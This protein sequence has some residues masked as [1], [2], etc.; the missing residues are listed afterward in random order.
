MFRRW[1]CACVA[2]LSLATQAHAVTG[3]DYSDLWWNPA[4]NGWGVGLQRQ[5]EVMFAALFLYGDDGASSWY[6]ASDMRALDE[7]AR[8]WSGKLYRAT[9]P[10]FSAPF[11]RPANVVE[12]GTATLD[13]FNPSAGR[14][15]YS[16][17]GTQVTKSIE[18]M[19]WRA[20]SIDGAYY[21]GM[22]AA[23]SQ[24]TDPNLDG[25]FDLM[26]PLTVATGGTRTTLTV[27]SGALSGSTSRC[28]LTGER[29]Q[30]G[31][32][33]S[34]EGTFSCSLVIGR[35]DRNDNNVT[36]LRNGTFVIDRMAM[37]ADGFS[38]RLAAVD[39][40][41]TYLGNFGGVKRP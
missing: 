5:G 2:A 19:S 3:V 36:V 4:E 8:S 30:A 7:P 1:L 20:P 35:D 13:F 18:R 38:A 9:A 23:L 22:T 31:R 11:D 21:G 6:F 14:L 12:V 24:C 10:A 15:T 26:G 16:V 37:S 28:T 32:L 29:R 17:N 27:T 39:Q 25:P 40:D 41:C 34:I 33:G